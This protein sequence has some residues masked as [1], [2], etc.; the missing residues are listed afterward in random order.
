VKETEM[1][2]GDLAAGMARRA[3]RRAR[4]ATVSSVGGILAGLEPAPFCAAAVPTI[5]HFCRVPAVLPLDEATRA[6]QPDDSTHVCHP[7]LG[8]CNQGYSNLPVKA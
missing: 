8:G 4:A 5:C 6:K 7:A 3:A 2:K 1:A